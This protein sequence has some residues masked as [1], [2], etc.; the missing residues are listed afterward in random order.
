M[1]F[2]VVILATLVGLLAWGLTV[3]WCAREAADERAEIWRAV[4]FVNGRRV[5]A[6]E[7]LMA[8]PR[9]GLRHA[10]RMLRALSDVIAGR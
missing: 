6:L 10:S 8:A 4:A 3:T 1:Q 9:D 2:V 7:S 5:R